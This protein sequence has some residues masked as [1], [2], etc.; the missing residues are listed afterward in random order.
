MLAIE[1]YTK[2]TVLLDTLTRESELTEEDIMALDHKVKAGIR[3]HYRSK[4]S[5]STGRIS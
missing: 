2:K 1:E 4:V 3:K 5:R